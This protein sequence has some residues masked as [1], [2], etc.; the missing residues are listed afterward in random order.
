[1]EVAENYNG[2]YNTELFTRKAIDVI[3]KQDPNQPFFLYFAHEAVHSA[4]P[5][6]PLQA[7]QHIIDQFKH[8]ENK[9]R[10]I[11]AAMVTSLDQSV[12]NI[13]S[14]LKIHRL[15][16]NTIVVFT[17]DNGGPAYFDLNIANNL[18]LR[19]RK[20]Q[21]WEGGVRGSACIYSPLIENRRVSMDMMHAT[22]W[23]PT[24]V[25]LA[26]GDANEMKQKDKALDGY[27]VWET[28]S[29]GIPSPRN[30]VLHNI[31]G[32]E[33]ALRVGDYKLLVHVHNSSWYPLP[34]ASISSS[35]EGIVSCHRSANATECHSEM[36][37][38][39]Y[40]IHLDPC[41][42]NNVA[43]M[44]PSKV[45]ELMEKLKDYNATAVPPRNKPVDPQS[46]PKLHN[47]VWSPWR[48]NGTIDVEA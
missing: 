5:S 45:Q 41:E 1:M 28:I 36:S 19:G 2:S 47:G 38:C 7:P 32:K 15:W 31:V 11:F 9:Q 23:L 26:G 18:P 44:M 29:K 42:Y 14:A 33:G 24:F 16:N 35:G 12:Q 46:N 17:T 30:E 6:D 4:N 37:P 22:D 48:T 20:A 13:T 25:H 34:T 27:N 43:A 3:A 40:N 10:Q 21:L 8:I 39:L